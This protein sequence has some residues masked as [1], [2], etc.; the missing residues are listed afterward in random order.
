[1]SQPG[2]GL[3]LFSSILLAP[4]VGILFAT[5]AMLLLPNFPEVVA[6]DYFYP[7]LG[8][9]F[10][11]GCFLTR[12]F[13]HSYHS[14][15]ILHIILLVLGIPAIPLGIVLGLWG[16]TGLQELPNPLPA[17]DP[18]IGFAMK[19]IKFEVTFIAGVFLL[20]I[21]SLSTVSAILG[22]KALKYRPQPAPPTFAS[23]RKW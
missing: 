5:L 19:Q 13:L 10:L 3:R 7:Y 2:D 22:L 11:A 18:G 21:G 9:L 23:P 8:F 14:T 16:Y 4:V 1:M 20:I 6:R 15:N 17:R 12:V